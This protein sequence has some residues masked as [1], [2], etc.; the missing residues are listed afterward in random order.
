MTPVSSS[1]DSLIE[2]IPMKEKGLINVIIFYKKRS[3]LWGKL[4]KNLFKGGS[5]VLSGG[6][7]TK[8]L[9]LR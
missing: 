9:E 3:S 1:R 6:R 8:L 5:S 7:K 4:D 2:K